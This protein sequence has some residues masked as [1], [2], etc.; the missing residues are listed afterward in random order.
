MPHDVATL[1]TGDDTG[2]GG[3]LLGN[4]GHTDGTLGVCEEHGIA[5]EYEAEDSG[6]VAAAL[7]REWFRRLTLFI[8]NNEIIRL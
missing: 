8:P 4:R 6:P 2:G 1:D 3:D 7:M 5:D